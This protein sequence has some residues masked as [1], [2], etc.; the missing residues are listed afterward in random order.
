MDTHIVDADSHKLSDQ[1]SKLAEA[2]D[3]ISLENRK[4]RNELVLTQ[5]VSSRLD[6]KIINLE[7]I[8][9]KGSSIAEGIS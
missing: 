3:Q 8:K 6:E 9:R 1:L 5:N 2:I 7:K 4:L